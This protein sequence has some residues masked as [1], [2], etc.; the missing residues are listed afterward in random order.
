MPRQ[1]K[2]MTALDV[3]RASHPQTT[4]NPVAF[5]AGGVAGLQ[6]QVTVNGAKS[7]LLRTTIAGK[8]RSIGLGAYPEVGLADARDAARA[9][10]VKIRQGTDPVE[11]R[12]AAL[13]AVVAEQ[14]RALTFAQ[15]VAGFADAK[16]DQYKTEKNRQLWRNMMESY[17]VPVLGSMRVQ[18]IKVHDVLQVV[19]PIWRTKTVTATT[20]RGRIE[21]VL[22]WATVK[23]HR[24]GDNPARWAGNLKELLP[25]PA[26]VTRVDH[27]AAVQIEQASAWFAEVRK[28][29]G[30]GSRALEFLALTAARSGEVRGAT[31]GEVDLKKGLWVVDAERMKMEREHRVP[32]SE[33]AI[34]VLSGLPHR[35]GLLFPAQRG[36]VLSDAA[37]GATMTRIHADAP[38]AGF[39][40]RASKRPAVPHGLRSTF[41]DWAAESTNFAGDLVEMALAHKV[42]NAVEAA[43]RRGDMMEKRKVLMAAWAAHLT[44]VK[45]VSNVVGL[46][47]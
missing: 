37:V 28:R 2:E 10:K 26:K 25:P 20:V 6:L 43:Y 15:A 34:A 7:W 44:G 14:R 39:L 4:P 1:A 41:R 9:A 38:D 29:G 5:A 11:E 30:N 31:W 36:G 16:L 8:R 3:K 18:D 23:G 13:A 46:V 21:N 47:G 32:L 40:D 17:A 35:T 33:A 22:D 24:S 19:E 45:S 12:L 27:H 42:S